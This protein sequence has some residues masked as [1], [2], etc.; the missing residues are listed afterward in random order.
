MFSPRHPGS[1]PRDS[2]HRGKEISEVVNAVWPHGATPLWVRTAAGRICATVE[3]TKHGAWVSTGAGAAVDEWGNAGEKDE[4]GNP[5]EAPARNDPNEAVDEVLEC[6]RTVARAVHDM[7]G[8]ARGL[9]WEAVD[10][11]ETR[12]GEHAVAATCVALSVARFG[13]TRYELRG[14]LRCR[15]ERERVRVRFG[16]GG[17]KGAN[18]SLRKLDDGRLDAVVDDLAPWLAPWCAKEAWHAELET[19]E[20]DRL[21]ASREESEA[22]AARHERESRRRRTLS[23]PG[24]PTYKPDDWYAAELPMRFRDD[25]YR[26]AALER[27]APPRSASLREEF[28]ADL[29]AYFL[30]VA[31]G[32]GSRALRADT[33]RALRAGLWHA[34]AGRDV[35]SVAD[36]LGRRGVMACLSRPGARS[37][38]RAVCCGEVPLSCGGRG[39]IEWR[40]G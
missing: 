19:F 32:S 18:E 3:E 31:A 29:A 6:P 9:F 16:P 26:A 4:W 13:V 14:A 17:A 34:A 1:T 39:A 15:F 22:R 25:A 2:H 23:G 11:M 5:V 24:G 28:H 20:G 7:P 33:R 10:A 36:V 8:T 35:N 12:H 38:V 21:G 27:Y 40:R 37:D 30:D